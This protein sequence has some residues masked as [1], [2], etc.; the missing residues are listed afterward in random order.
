MRQKYHRWTNEEDQVIISMYSTKASMQEIA[1]ALGV[2]V[3]QIRNRTSYLRKKGILNS[4]L[5]FKWTDT[6]EKELVNI[7]HKN[8]G[9][10]RNGFREFAEANN[11]SREAVEARYYHSSV[12]KPKVM[13]KY[14]IFTTIGRYRRANNRKIYNR[15]ESKGHKIWNIIKGFFN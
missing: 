10:L 5:T 13:D 9:N 4:Y 6:K 2:R 15:Q 14:P 12:N 11:I 3:E 8:E 7:L 1:D